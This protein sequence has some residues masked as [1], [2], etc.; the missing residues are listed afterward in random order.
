MKIL[1]INNFHYEFGGASVVYLN[2][3][4]ILENQGHQVIFF[5]IKDDN[6]LQT[7]SE[8]YF[9]N[10]KIKV[11]VNNKNNAKKF[12]NYFYNKQAATNLDLLL[13]ENKPDIAHIHLF[14]GGITSSILP[15]LKKN[16]VP[17]VYTAHDYRLI[18]PA[19]TFLNGSGNICESCK[20]HAFYKCTINRCSKG[21]LLQSF[22]MSLEMYYR[23]IFFSPNKYIDAFI[24]VSNF[25]KIKNLQYMPKLANKSTLVLYNSSKI[26]RIDT[27]IKE[28]YFLYYGRISHEKGLLTLLSVFKNL[29][30]VYLKIVGTGPLLQKLKV[31][32]NDNKLNNVD[33]LG[34]KTGKELIEIVSKAYF[35]IVPSEWYENNPM[36]IVESY[37]LG[38]PVIGAEIGGIS[39]IIVNAETGYTFVSRDSEDLENKIK[40]SMSLSKEQ[41]SKMCFKAN[42]FALKYFN[43]TEYYSQ[44]IDFYTNVI[45]NKK[46]NI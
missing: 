13:K 32:V 14:Y 5:S 16:G 26:E 28:N 31:Y 39:E 21:N 1:L 15:V 37:S 33:F 30:N 35:V 27:K 36:T 44:I 45:E 29:P 40:T 19:Y 6:N 18:C 43:E 3:A 12:T 7:D 25:S 24:F 41:Y 23:N 38:T 42:D 46:K 22:V 9:I 34:F 2:T 11:G 8:K 10:R 4:R 17:I 20:G